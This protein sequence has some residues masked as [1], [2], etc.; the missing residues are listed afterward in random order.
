MKKLLSIL[1]TI[2]MLVSLCVQAFADEPD[3][4]SGTPWL[5]ID[6]D[7][8]VTEDTPTN[9]KDNFILAVE[10][11]KLLS[12]RIPEGYSRIGTFT[13]VGLQQREDVKNMF[14]GEPPEGH[15][16]RLAYDLFKLMM[17]WD[18]RNAVGVAPLKNRVDAVEAIDSVDAL[19][20]YF[21]ETPFA[22]RLAELWTGDARPDP[23]DSSR[24]ILS[25]SDCALL[26]DDSAEYEKPTDYGTVKRDARRG[27]V[28][29]VL[30]KMGY[31]EADAAQKVDNCLA[32]EALIAPA[33]YTHEEQNRPDYYDRI[34]NYLTRD[35]LRQM[36]G[37]LPILETFSFAGFP[38][39]EQYLMLNPAFVQKLNELYT[40]E[41][42]PLIKDYLIVH[43]VQSEAYYFDR[44]CYEWVVEAS[45]AISG[46]SGMLSD[47]IVFSNNVSAMLSWPVAQLYTQTYL[48]QED[49]DRISDLV[50]ELIDAYHGIL[51]EAD[52]L[53]DTTRAAAI[54]K[55]DSIDI[56]VLFPDSWEKYGCEELNFAGP[57]DGG[58]LWEARR[59][60][61]EYQMAETV[62]DYSGPVDKQKWDA[63]PQT[64]NCCYNPENNSLMILGAYAQGD[65]YN[66]DMSDEE[67]LGKIGAV[68]GHEISHAFDAYGSQFDK[69]GNMANWWTDED[70]A[71]FQERNQ[72]LEDYF[73][74]MHPWAGQD[75]H[76]SIMTGEACADMAGFKAALRLASERENF[77]YDAFFRAFADL[78]ISKG[79]LQA[80]YR[81]INDVHPL[82]YLRIN[83]T[84]QQ[85]DEFL[86]FYGITEGD[87]MYLAPAD[88]VNIW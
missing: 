49:K 82:G 50:D 11:D 71:A 19:S 3:Y 4:T 18:S 58:T 69:D 5:C 63:T 81:S 41:N 37:G 66:S 29:K 39:A 88:R 45:N 54:E 47:E 87:G 16:T 60:I 28:E 72:K 42:L 27:L 31:S 78:W 52:F 76:G 8:T 10:K 80:V 33:L 67:L 7:G 34:R 32:F 74:A 48:K 56:R 65:N 85:Y 12:L 46:A 64:V 44:E 36:Q 62:R 20:A 9:L 6:L 86:D 73:N 53:S 30:R 55:L 15:D 70:L 75:F 68:I 24:Y 43:G 25:V 77:D 35:E 40:D 57:E 38:E 22:D 2:T 13:A 26:M 14:L 79:T 84:L 61:R 59:A 23:I 21:T 83:C 17:D 1:L 51:G